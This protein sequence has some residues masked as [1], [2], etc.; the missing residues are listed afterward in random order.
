[1]SVARRK[2][3]TPEIAI[4]R[5]LHARGLRYQVAYPIPGQHRRSIDIAFTPSKVAVFVDGCFWHGCPDHGTRPRSNPDWW[6]TKL[7]A[8]AA[9]DPDTNRVLAELGWTVL[10]FWEHED[11]HAAASLISGALVLPPQIGTSVRICGAGAM[12]MAMLVVPP[13]A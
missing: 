11:P 12:L 5:V 13:P 2:D 3:T 10:R 7:A 1:M 4:R 8:H 9:R 6:R